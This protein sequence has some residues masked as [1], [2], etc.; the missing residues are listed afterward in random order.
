MKD[1]NKQL[2]KIEQ[3]QRDYNFTFSTPEGKR[4]LKHLFGLCFVLSDT[5]VPGKPDQ[6]AYNQGRRAVF[7][8]IERLCNMDISELRRLRKERGHELA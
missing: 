5:F 1:P 4:V 3:L 6:S 8:E 7:M 2:D